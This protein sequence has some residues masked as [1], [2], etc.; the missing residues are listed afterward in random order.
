M[1]TNEQFFT[2][3]NFKFSIFGTVPKPDNDSAFILYK[4]GGNLEN[5]LAIT[6][7]HP[8]LASQIRAGGFN[9]IMKVSLRWNPFALQ[10]EIADETNNFRFRVTIKFQ[11]RIKNPVYIFKNKAGNIEGEIQNIVTQAVEQEHRKYDI[12]SQIELEQKLRVIVA[13][14]LQERMYL[15]C[16][17]INITA[18]LDERAKNIIDSNLDA[19]AK[20]VVER[21]ESEQ[22]IRQIEQGRKIEIQK[23]EAEKE[24]EKGR[25]ALNLEKADGMK[26]LENKLGE[27]YTTF[28]AY[29]NG[30]ISNVEF[31]ERMHQNRNAAMVAK[32]QCLKQLAEMNVL[33]E[34][35]LERAALKL[36][37]EDAGDNVVERHTITDSISAEKEIVVED[38]EE[39]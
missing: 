23:L 3:D 20:D 29:I 10:R 35:A 9:K 38:T 19:M 16:N 2:V 22:L 33:L 31:D 21:N 1:N 17:G 15:E 8:V 14:K 18:E 39:Y 13:Q 25:N 36:L 27:D 34:P 37:G 24:I 28:L 4:E 7:Q 11:Y 30:E 5:I 6:P 12:E 26:A 32:I